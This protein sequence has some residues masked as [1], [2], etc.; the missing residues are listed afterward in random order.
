MMRLPSVS[1]APWVLLLVC[2][3]GAVS[4]CSCDESSSTASG[5]SGGSTTTGTT[6]TGFTGGAGTGGNC[7]I[8]SPCEG[9]VCTE[10][11]TC[12]PIARACAENCCGATDVCSFSS[13]VAPGA[14]CDENEDCAATEFCDFTLGD[15][16]MGGGG[17]GGGGGAGGDMCQGSMRPQGRCMPK[18]PLC[19]NGME[20]GDPPTCVTACEYRPPIGVFQP[21]EKYSWGDITNP[22]HNVMMSPI[23]VQLDDDNCD[24]V[25]DENDIPEII[26]FTFANGD[27]NNG[28][29][30]AST[31]RAISVVNGAFVE[32]LAI[33]TDGVS[34]DSPGR[35][36]AAGN[37]DG[38]PEPEIV[39][40]TVDGRIRAYESDGSIKWLS[41][42]GSCFMPNIADLDQDG[43]PE[44]IDSGYILDGETG[45]TKAT[46]PNE[47]VV[48][49][50]VTGDGKLDVVGSRR[51]FDAAGAVIADS[52]LLGTHSAVGDLNNDGRPE[53]VTVDFITH[54]MRV[55]NI[56]P[57]TGVNIIR[58]G[59]DI[60]AGIATNKCCAINPNSAGCLYGGGP[61]TIARFGTDAFPDV[62]FASGIGYIVYDGQKLMDGTP[63]D[64]TRLWLSSDT[65][66]C[67][68]AQTGSSVFD[69]DGDGIAEV[70]YADE[71]ELHIF[72]GPT[73]QE[74]FST[75]N[76]SGTLWEYPLVADV[77][78]DGHADIIMASNWYSGL[79]CGGTKTTGIRVFGDNEGKWVR[80][81]RIWNQHAYHV[82]NVNED[83]SVPMVEPINHLTP[84]LNNFRQNVQ[85]GSQFAAPD[86][87]VS[88]APVCEGPYGL[89]ARVY[90]LGE[91]PVEAGVPVGFYVGDAPNG[92]SLGQ[93]ITQKALYPLS[94]EDVILPLTM[95]PAGR[96]YAVVDDG[97]PVH[98][99]HECRTDNNTSAST[100]PNCAVPQ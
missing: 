93:G 76:T 6:A 99:W 33:Q 25:I 80:T 53:I 97:M 18:P 96:V 30:T 85:P 26:F 19:P 46:L 50:D 86:L 72:A 92:T 69:F 40:C 55:W 62:A 9:G 31:L 77:D 78:N 70:V 75:C 52:G 41:A 13:C 3:A 16:G 37:I 1:H 7:P 2:T 73:G 95:V 65:Q 32:K 56:D 83:G 22:E 28:S 14:V 59:I 8:G 57:V 91:A 100:D 5:G 39:V 79:N 35:Q 87:V 47:Y 34:A 51:V 24:Q 89:R 27:Y 61:P 66:D 67:S 20:P 49:A 82:T 54:T 63:A 81:R 15:N 44:I 71:V 10:N 84:G 45:A 88:L 11:N 60:N 98:P 68:S 48:V 29:G 64:Q 38:D 4:S 43:K 74:L 21:I 17:M 23:I 36:I 94:Y 12:C 42:P 58:Q 90:N